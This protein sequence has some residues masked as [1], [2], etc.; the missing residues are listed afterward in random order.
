MNLYL[1]RMNTT[2][3]QIQEYDICLGFVICAETGPDAREIAAQSGDGDED[4]LLWHDASVTDCTLIGVASD[5]VPVGIVLI[6]FK[7]G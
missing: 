2:H 7:A 1:L 3:P 4:K 5:D 6:D